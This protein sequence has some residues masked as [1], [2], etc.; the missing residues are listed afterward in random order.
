MTEQEKDL[1]T[2]RKL[3]QRKLFSLV[4]SVR[5]MLRRNY[6]V[7]FCDLGFRMTKSDGGK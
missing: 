7:M 4:E 6:T 1:K 5:S 3:E 2:K